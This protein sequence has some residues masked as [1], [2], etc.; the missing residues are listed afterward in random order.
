M[1]YNAPNRD[2]SLVGTK[3]PSAGHV[4][5]RRM[6][7]GKT[8]PPFVANHHSLRWLEHQRMI[9][10]VLRGEGAG[11]S[12]ADLLHAFLQRGYNPQMASQFVARARR[13][14]DTVDRGPVQQRQAVF[15]AG[16][17]GRMGAIGHACRYCGAPAQ[18]IDHVWPQSRGG[19]D[20]PN[21]LVRSCTPC[22]SVKSNQ[23][24]LT[25]RCPACDAFRD[26]SDVITATGQAFYH[27]RCGTVWRRTWDFQTEIRSRRALPS[28]W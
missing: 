17:L 27:C 6:T 11:L 5:A 25:D 15:S 23:S 21:N 28:Q 18:A 3:R 4:Q 22:N 19:D 10:E 9:L 2:A 7:G 12:D 26:P 14:L 20:H 1:P 16:P 13:H 24:W 8:R